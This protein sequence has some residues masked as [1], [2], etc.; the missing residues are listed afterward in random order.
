MK[1]YNYKVYFK[2]EGDSQY[3]YNMSFGI[4]ANSNK[5][6]VDIGQERWKKQVETRERL[7]RA[8]VVK[9][10]CRAFE[11]KPRQPRQRKLTPLEKALSVLNN[12]I[13]EDL[14]K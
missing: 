8:R 14:N 13:N 2:L 3:R 10:T 12:Y 11:T 9:T 5:E 1:S 6:A 4:Q 7:K